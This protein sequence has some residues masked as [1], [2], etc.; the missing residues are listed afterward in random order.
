MKTL[1]PQLLLL[2][3]LALLVAC[4]DSKTII[5]GHHVADPDEHHDEHDDHGHDD[6]HEHEESVHGRLVITTADSPMVYVLDAEDGEVLAELIVP[7]TPTAINASADYR[8]ASV[9]AR[10]DNWV[11][12]IDGGLSLEDHGDHQ[13]LVSETPA[14][15]DFYLD[16]VRPSHYT[17]SEDQVAVF[18]DGNGDLGEPAGVAVF[19]SAT[20]AD[21]GMPAV[22]PL[23]THQHG[24]AQARGEHLL[25][26]ERDSATESTLPDRVGLYHQHG[27]HYDHELTF[28]VTCPGLHGSA[29]NE[30]LI[31]FG[32]TDGVLVIDESQDFSARKIANPESFAENMRIGSVYAHHHVED[33]IAVAAGQYFV[34]NAATD[35]IAPLAWAEAGEADV[36]GRGFAAE[37]EWFVLLQ[38]NGLLTVIDA[39]DWEEVGSLSLLAE[40]EVA[41][42]EAG[43]Q[44]VLAPHGHMAY[45]LEAEG[46]HLHAIDLEHLEVEDQWTL[47]FT[48]ARATWLG[49]AGT[50]SAESSNH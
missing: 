32:C 6:D 50:D 42:D 36:V 11:S 5:N 46:D 15:M 13:D 12:F 21:N 48:P 8:Y 43:Y 18:Y 2:A 17:L 30:D 19:D 34:V 23:S 29:Q 4:G 16:G 40:G 10:N 45:V 49:V 44:L 1:Y 26:T 33:A 38:A 37:G 22:L 7:A 24:A 25:A 47:D 31:F 27:D 35:S 9:I 20:I 28:E 39:H 41:S 14:I 3:L